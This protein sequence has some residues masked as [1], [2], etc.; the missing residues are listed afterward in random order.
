MDDELF[1]SRA[2][3]SAFRVIRLRGII[4]LILNL[5]KDERGNTRHPADVFQRI[6]FGA[7]VHSGR[8]KPP[9]PAG[10][11]PGRRLILLE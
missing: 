11:P 1:R 10:L 5:L 2:H 6:R 7:A 9:Q 3:Y 8:P 4:P